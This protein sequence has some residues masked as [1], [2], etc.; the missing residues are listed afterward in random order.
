MVIYINYSTFYDRWLII[1]IKVE[2]SDIGLIM[3]KKKDKKINTN[4]KATATCSK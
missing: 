4:N 1:F 2:D 3:V